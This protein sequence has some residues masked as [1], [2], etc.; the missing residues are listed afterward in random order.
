A[1][2]AAPI[3]AAAGIICSNSAVTA[4]VSTTLS[5]KPPGILALCK[6]AAGYPLTVNAASV[7]ASGFALAVDPNGGFNAT[8]SGASTHTFTF[9]AQ[10]SQGTVGAATTVTLTF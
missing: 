2:G 9:K 6:D 8:V 1:L 5:I 7:T 3:E 4:M 10:N